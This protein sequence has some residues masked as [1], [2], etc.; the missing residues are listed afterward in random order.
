MPSILQLEVNQTTEELAVSAKPDDVLQIRPKYDNTNMKFVPEKIKIYPSAKEAKFKITVFQTG[1]FKVQFD[2][3]GMYAA[4]FKKPKQLTI[5][6]YQKVDIQPVNI[7]KTFLDA[8]CNNLLLNQCDTKIK[9]TSTCS[10]NNGTN[11]FVGVESENLKIPLSLVGLDEKTVRT[12]NISKFLNPLNELK[13]YLGKRKIKASCFRSCNNSNYNNNAI[14]FITKTNIFQRA[15]LQ[16]INSRLP[17]WLRINIDPKE[18]YFD[19]YNFLT[20]LGN[21]AY[22]RNI[23]QCRLSDTY[24]NDIHSVY[25]PKLLLRFSIGSVLKLTADTEQSTCF[26]INLCKNTLSV[27]LHEN[28][29]LNYDGHLPNI[30][31]SN[32]ILRVKGFTFGINESLCTSFEKLK[33]CIVVNAYVDVLLSSHFHSN[34]TSILVEG[35]LYTA[36]DDKVKIFFP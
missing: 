11:G 14:N 16:Q 24:I 13:S 17:L 3:V 35:R 6:G 10:W 4:T 12:F 28:N 23:K 34:G 19:A 32:S 21:T 15:Y 27:F 1:I 25:L 2:L 36:L 22:V 29:Y 31:M 9:L 7:D 8:N 20:F 26:D 30:G 5:Y 33:E 18:R